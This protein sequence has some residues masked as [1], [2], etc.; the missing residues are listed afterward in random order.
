MCFVLA[1]A[2]KLKVWNLKAVRDRMKTT[3]MTHAKVGRGFLF[4]LQYFFS[5]PY[6][7]PM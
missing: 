1:Y 2:L 3:F 4:G 7:F 6:N 5:S